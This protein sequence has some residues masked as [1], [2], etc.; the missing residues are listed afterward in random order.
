L[1]SYAANHWSVHMSMVESQRAELPVSLEGEPFHQL[2]M[3][4]LKDDSK[5]ESVVQISLFRD[6]SSNTPQIT[7]TST[8]EFY[9]S[10]L[11]IRDDVRQFDFEVDPLSPN[12]TT[13]LSLSC[14]LGLS[15]LTK[16]LLHFYK[17]SRITTKMNQ[18]DAFL[19]SPLHWAVLSGQLSIVEDLLAEGASCDLR[20]R[21]K[22]TAFQLAAACSRT[23]IAHA[24][25]D[26][27]YDTASL[28]NTHTTANTAEPMAAI[29]AQAAATMQD[30]FERFS[31]VVTPEDR[32]LFDTTTLTDV[33]DGAIQ[34]ERVLRARRTQK[35]MAQLDPFL[36][37]MQ[38]Y[39][40]I[41]EVMS[42]GSPFLAWAWAPVKLMLLV[43]RTPFY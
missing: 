15:F 37:G 41:A 39:S 30:A 16:Q 20:N 43:S 29:S 8:K 2:A 4:F 28:N 34:I 31:S 19:E 12:L 25:L 7:P 17:L 26:K 36:R 1:L 18:Q 6:S 14:R 32:R 38:H 33:R 9:A 21:S 10:V 40:K 35:N 24:I 13:G 23:R 42:N 5:V 11:A 27:T 3:E 22:K